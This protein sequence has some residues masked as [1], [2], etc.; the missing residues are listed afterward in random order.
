MVCRWFGVC[1]KFSALFLPRAD[2]E[3]HSFSPDTS[4]DPSYAVSDRYINVIGHVRYSNLISDLW[5]RWRGWK[6]AN[7]LDG[8]LF[9]LLS[10]VNVCRVNQ[11]CL[12]NV[13]HQKQHWHRIAQCLCACLC[14]TVLMI[15]QIKCLCLLRL[16]KKLRPHFRCHYFRYGVL[17]AS[18]ISC[19]FGGM[20]R[21]TR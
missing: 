15:P 14:E 6:W 17:L 3:P 2:F 5:F 13:L 19:W 18:G 8:A 1:I 20:S 7:S 4:M 21:S 16:I 12:A 10:L 9:L 11:K